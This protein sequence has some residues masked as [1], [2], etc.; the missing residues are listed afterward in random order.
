MNYRAFGRLGW[1]VSEVG[2][3]MWG[4]AGGE[5]GWTGSDDELGMQALQFAVN[6]GCNFFDTAWIYGRGHSEQMLGQLLRNNPDKP[7]VVATKVPPKNREWPSRRGDKLEDI[8][9]PEHIRKLFA[10]GH[11]AVVLDGDNLRHGLCRDLGFNSAARSENIRRVGEVA[12]LFLDQGS[13][14]WPR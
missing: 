4:I 2:Y 11:T 12:K 5:G 14:F 10:L 8:F 9:P 1:N 3:G 13:S 6:K 7:L